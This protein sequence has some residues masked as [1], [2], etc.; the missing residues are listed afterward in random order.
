M[1]DYLINTCS[2]IAKTFETRSPS[3]LTGVKNWGPQVKLLGTGSRRDSGE[4]GVTDSLG[5]TGVYMTRQGHGR[6]FLVS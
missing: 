3:S 1:K 2:L 6:T 4:G 5:G